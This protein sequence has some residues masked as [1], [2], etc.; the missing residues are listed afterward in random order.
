M[1]TNRSEW[2]CQN[3]V[4]KN[5]FLLVFVQISDSMLLIQLNKRDLKLCLRVCQQRLLNRGVVRLDDIA[6][7]P[8]DANA[9]LPNE[10]T[11]SWLADLVIVLSMGVSNVSSN[12]VHVE[13]H[14]VSGSVNCWVEFILDPSSHFDCRWDFDW[15]DEWDEAE[16]IQFGTALPL[17]F[18]DIWINDSLLWA[19]DELS[20]LW[21][22]RSIM[23]YIDVR[24][25]LRVCETNKWCYKVVLMETFHSQDDQHLKPQ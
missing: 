16:L 13:S 19:D 14:L 6:A 5:K 10:D 1:A 12:V 25:C 18:L 11:L 9:V 23:C 22:D 20:R 21:V 3:W 24:Y 15:F 2:F 17:S 8:W 4:F 7:E